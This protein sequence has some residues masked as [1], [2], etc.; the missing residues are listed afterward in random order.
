MWRPVTHPQAEAVY[1]SSP[2]HLKRHDDC[3]DGTAR[4]PLTKL[5]IRFDVCVCRCHQHQLK[6]KK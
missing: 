3:R 5:G 6:E 4:S 1:V 2:C